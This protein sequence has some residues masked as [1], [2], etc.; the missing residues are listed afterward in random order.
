MNEQHRQFQVGDLVVAEYKSGR[1]IG[2]IVELTNARKAAVEIAAVVQHP[3]QGDLHHPM[4]ADVAMF[5]QRRALAQR[6]IALM[7]LP[8][9]EQ[10]DG[11][12]PEYEQS[13]RQAVARQK[14]ELD[15]LRR[16]SERAISELAALER[17]YFG[18]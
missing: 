3:E 12:V 7:P 17:E 4:Q 1:Y 5:H 14:Q 15:Q 11:P 16:W 10:Y 18:N 13:L 6:E 9:I 2:R 8:A